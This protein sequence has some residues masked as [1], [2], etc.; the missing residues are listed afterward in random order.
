L[1]TA[2][3]AA[4]VQKKLFSKFAIVLL[5]VL[6]SFFEPLTFDDKQQKA[7]AWV[8]MIIMS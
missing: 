7:A 4:C 2:V 8:M 5:R 6:T 1:W 3:F